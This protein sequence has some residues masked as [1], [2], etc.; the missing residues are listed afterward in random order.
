[1]SEKSSLAIIIPCYNE[2]DAV[3][4]FS[5]EIEHFS[6]QFKKKFPMIELKIVVVNNNSS[7]GCIELLKETLKS[8]N[9]IHI[10]DCSEQGYGAALKHGFKTVNSDYY[11][12]ADL[13]N[14]YPFIKLID[15]FEVI[16]NKS[17][18]WH[19]ISGGRLHSGSQIPFIRNL[20]NHMYSSLTRI[21]F[22]SP[23]VD[24]C[25]GMRIFSLQ[26]RDSIVKLK[27][28]DLSFSIELTAYALKNNWNLKEIP[29]LY[30]ER[31]GK[32]KLSVI[33]DGFIFLFTLLKVKL[34]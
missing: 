27:R 26:V 34:S 10:I 18:N 7:D 24:T 13:D 30:R 15:M 14:T 5:D 17:E 3:L 12:F 33:N 25:S 16:T 6:V 9:S 29:I 8:S 22:S 21:L 11:A 1:M 32:S 4:Q 31:L 19:M 2:Y 28:N 23:I 20:G